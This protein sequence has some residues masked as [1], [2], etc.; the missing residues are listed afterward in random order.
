MS[1][2]RG[3]LDFRKLAGKR[4]M[5]PRIHPQRGLAL[6]I[7]L[8]FIVMLS[9]LVVGVL[10]LS[11]NETK[12]AA[13][14]MN[15]VDARVAA[16]SVLQIVQS[17]IRAATVAGINPGTKQG[18]YTWASQPGAIR[19]FDN[20][21]ALRNIYKLYSSADMVAT[22]AQFIA[23][24]DD[25]PSDWQARP[26]EFVDLNEPVMRGANQYIYPI[27]SPEA[28]SG[29]NAVVGFTS[30]R[31]QTATWDDRLAM[32]VRWLYVQKDG[33]MSPDPAVGD[34]V[35]RIAFWTDDEASKINVNTASAT[36]TNSYMDIPRANYTSER[37]LAFKQPAQN[38]YNRYPGHPA[39]VSLLTVFSGSLADLVAASPRYQ[40]GGS[41]DGTLRITDGT[42]VVLNGAK[43]DRLFATT[44]EYLYSGTVVSGSPRTK[45][46]NLDAAGLDAKRFFLTATSRSS[47]LNL[48]GQPRVTIWP[49]SGIDDED[50]RTPYD[51]LIAFCSTIGT[52]ASA[53]P[54]YFLRSNPLS[55]TFDW[56]NYPQNK[57]VFDFLRAQT[58]KE[59][60]GF[61]GNFLNKYDTVSGGVSGERDEI[62]TEIFDYIRCVNLNDTYK[63]QPASFKPYT[64]KMDFS[65]GMAESTSTYVNYPGPGYVLPILINDY[66]TRGAGRVPVVSELGLWL[67]QTEATFASGSITH[68]APDPP[69]VQPA[70]IVETFS[71]MQGF[72]PWAPYNFNM[73]VKGT[74]T[75][76]L[77]GTD[78]V[79]RSLFP[80]AAYSGGVLND[81]TFATLAGPSGAYNNGQ[82]AGG[83]DGWAWTMATQVNAGGAPSVATNPFI[84]TGSLAIPVSGSSAPASGNIE[85][86]A[87]E[88]EIQLKCDART[89]TTLGYNKKGGTSFQTYHIKIPQMSLPIPEPVPWTLSGTIPSG[90]GLTLANQNGWGMRGLTDPQ[91]NAK[92]VV[93][94]LP[95]RN[96]DYRTIA[97]MHDVPAAAFASDAASLPAAFF[98]GSS[99]QVHGFRGGVNSAYVGTVNGGYVAGVAYGSDPPLA[100]GQ[101][102][103]WRPKIGPKI[104]SLLN[105]GW[106]G[107]FDNGMA[108]LVDGPYLN[109]SDEGSYSHAANQE[110]YFYRIWHLGAGL[111]SPSRQMPSAV[112]FGSLPTGVKRTEAA[113]N[114]GNLGTA[115]PWRTL[116]FCPNPPAGS[117]HFGL[118]NP[119]DYL[120]LDLFTMPI[121]EPYAISEPFSTAGRLNMNYQIVPFT[122]IS[123]KT[124]MYAAL[125]AQKVVAI[126][127]AWASDYKSSTQSATGVASKQLRYA[128]D[129][130]ETLKQF[131]RRFNTTKDIFHSATEICS[132]S[133]IP[134]GETES[135]YAG[136][137]ATR[138]LTGNNLRERPYATLYPL[139]TTKSNVYTTHLRAQAIKRLPDGR[140]DVQGEYR[141]SVNFERYLDPN[142]QVFTSGTVDP[143]TVSLEPYFRFRT[144]V[145]KQFDP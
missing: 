45:Q 57:R 124:A 128:I 30:T 78:G 51:Q 91:F 112:V 54:Y 8:G 113:Y 133:L 12:T 1:D 121:V 64:T 2:S 53:K 97:Y 111:F 93:R 36:G 17:Q 41:A 7:V 38:E 5:K 42:R 31:S 19:V 109:K 81:S 52:G 123:R 125:A 22:D 6:V 32:P 90:T 37:D 11:Q 99:K 95:L 56:D 66:G 10:V 85:I 98:D 107:D 122:H 73:Q 114:S 49:I 79:S 60:P 115:K 140:I 137:W 13:R 131:D 104:S 72:M 75:P 69:R 58:S 117:A 46:L 3:A 55:Q 27:A 48:S 86:T 9:I 108:N 16:D 116:N 83:I 61:G 71:P 44:D 106:E 29:S 87:G 89:P 21:G 14:M 88:L 120:L 26:K 118:T 142:D 127:D 129:A 136:W 50:H 143:D 65:Q 102:F 74:I 70:L 94:G 134:A 43:R 139:L 4:G 63:D 100:T 33:S 105:E 84:T 138:N 62:L 68:D 47:D 126:S 18:E 77:V 35:L 101:W 24:G 103:S 119:P 15:A 110:P 145:A 76:A 20:T 141:G 59:I 130:A 40:W 34:P 135:S 82:A 80:G 28:L 92:D 25:I 132:I 144:L 96:G 23:N 67:I 39:T